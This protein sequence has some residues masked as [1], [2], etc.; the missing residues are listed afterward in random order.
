MTRHLAPVE[1]RPRIPRPRRIVAV[2]NLPLS[3]LGLVALFTW[4][5]LGMIF[6]SSRW[7]STPA[8]GNLL[9][10][11]AAPTW[12]WIY[13]GAAAVLATSLVL[14][15]YRWLGMVAHTLTFALLVVWE[16]A[17]IIRW[18]TDDHTTDVNV[19]SWA[20]FLA[21]TLRSGMVAIAD[22]DPDPDQPAGPA[23]HTGVPAGLGNRPTAE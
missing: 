18:I 20:F 12:G 17:F 3:T 2:W 11:F 10:I 7:Y 14:R 21:V 5:A 4:F 6:Q 15:R 8:Y 19:G 13:L 16:A 1:R 23:V 9:T 22:P